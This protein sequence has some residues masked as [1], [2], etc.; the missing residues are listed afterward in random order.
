MSVGLGP[1]SL[2]LLAS[3]WGSSPPPSVRAASVCLGFQPL[4]MLPIARVV[5]GRA[6][7]VSP[8]LSAAGIAGNDG[9]LGVS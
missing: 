1:C 6:R 2:V 5:W 4:A 7:A 3:A 8:F 9:C